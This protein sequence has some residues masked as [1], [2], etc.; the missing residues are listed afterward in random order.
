MRNEVHEHK[1]LTIPTAII[2]ALLAAVIT[3]FGIGLTIAFLP[4]Q[5]T[6]PRAPGAPNRRAPPPQFL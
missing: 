6:A 1:Q 2:L 3:F 5:F 4:S